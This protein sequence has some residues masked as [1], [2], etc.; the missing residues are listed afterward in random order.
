MLPEEIVKKIRVI[1]IRTKLLVDQMFSGEYQSVFK[2]RGIEFSEVRE[3]AYGDDTRSIDWNVTARYGKP[4]IK[5][6]EEERELTVLILFDMS[7]STLFGSGESTKRDLMT[8]L[9]ALFAFSA[10]ENNDRVGAVLFSDR[11]EKYIPPKKDKTHALRILR[12]LVYFEP[13]AKRTDLKTAL[14]FINTLR[15]SRS[16]VFVLSDFFTAGCDKQFKVTA[17][18]HDVIPVVFTDP[19][20]VAIAEHRGILFLRDGETGESR[21]VDLA[22]T[23]VRNEYRGAL[24]RNAVSWKRLFMSIGLDYIEVAAGGPYL[25]RLFEFFERRARKL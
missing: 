20:E 22:D 10:V 9:A 4:F 8:E 13:E 24:K 25:K 15:V 21:Y 5:M 12:D 7:A 6:Y 18:K 19:M 1:D 14:D 3:Y 23:A 2:G 11:V 16:V 17:K